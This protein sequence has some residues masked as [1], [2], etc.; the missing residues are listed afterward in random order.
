MEAQSIFAMELE[1]LRYYVFDQLYVTFAGPRPLPIT[2]MSVAIEFSHIVAAR[3]GGF[4][5]GVGSV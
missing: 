2:E 1:R 4:Q 3:G 5:S